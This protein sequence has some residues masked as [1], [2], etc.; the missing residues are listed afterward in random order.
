MT[1][2]PDETFEVIAI[3]TVTRAGDIS[4]ASSV[5]YRTVDTDTFTFG[6][7]DAVNNGGGAYGRCDFV[8]AVGTLNFAAGEAGKTIG[9]SV[10]D[11]AH[12]EGDESFQVTLS[13]PAGAALSQPATATVSITDNDPGGAPNPVVAYFG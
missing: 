13:N 12:V 3:L 1:S 4:A 2:E 11:D 6:C 8:T 9:V 7:A 10:I 5:D